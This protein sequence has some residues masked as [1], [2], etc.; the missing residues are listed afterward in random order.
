MN[1]S[2]I[3]KGGPIPKG[4][5]KKNITFKQWW[6]QTRLKLQNWQAKRKKRNPIFAI[7]MTI[8][9]MALI[10]FITLPALNP[11]SGDL[12]LFLINAI[13]VYNLWNIVLGGIPIHKI[14][15][16]SLMTMGVLL[17]IPFIG[18]LISTPLFRAKAYANRIPMETADFA[19]TVKEISYDKVPVVDRDAA[20]IIGSRQ[21]GAVQDVVSQFEINENYT[22]I[23][24]KNV[25][26]RVT[27]LAYDGIIKYFINQGKGIPYFVKVDMATQDAELVK[28]SKN[29]F[30]S[31]SDILMRDITRHLRF[32]YPTKI[33]GETNFEVDDNGNP[34]YVT[35][36]MTKRIGFFNG[37]DV[38][39]AII[40]DANSG[41][42]TLYPLA[43]VPKWVDRVFPSEL[44]IEQL[45]DKGRFAKGFMNSFIGQQNVTK[46]TDGYNYIPM[47]DDIW[48]FTGVT[49]VR[50]D[51]SNL[52]FYFVNLRTKEAKFFSVPS[53][54]ETSA[55]RSAE[56]QVQEKAYQATFPILLNINNR[57]T[58]LIG[59]K[60]NSGLAKM[61][62]L[63]DAENY[64]NVTV[65]ASTQEVFRA[66]N[67]R[68]T[69]VDQP[70]T[71]AVEKN[72]VIENIQSVV[73]EGNTVYFIQ[74]KGDPLIYTGTAKKLGAK[75][76][77]A[78]PGDTLKVYG[79]PTKDQFNILELR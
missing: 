48:L 60:D 52:G 63:V 50:S 71:N 5:G 38:E 73:M 49:S 54:N 23:N 58:Y 10:F 78:K 44:I 25:P 46:T 30:Y 7:L 9:T 1:F 18:N 19:Q 24:I 3:P 42:S 26:V 21:M 62:A 8:L 20:A 31:N 39:G 69:P 64:Q 34:Y 59:L 75:V 2:D 55:M 57:P 27:P 33:F 67:A 41:Q 35:S 29:I 15:R 74:A 56:G 17:L 12:Y 4:P 66:H 79:N 70:A 76:V 51:S 47:N 13:L 36:V 61:F 6:A 28:L 65:A 72:I 53:A 68:T 77:F 22:Q 45:D 43:E 40:T 37:T 11:M 32:Q 14:I 16:P